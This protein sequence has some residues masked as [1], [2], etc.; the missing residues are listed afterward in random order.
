[1]NSNLIELNTGIIS[2]CLREDKIFYSQY[3]NK[4]LPSMP[5]LFFIGLKTLKIEQLQ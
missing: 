3:L 5:F 2:K 4:K 1:M